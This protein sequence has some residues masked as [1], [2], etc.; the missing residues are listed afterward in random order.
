MSPRPHFH[1]KRKT[2]NLIIIIF[3][4][5]F[6]FY[7]HLSQPC[8]LASSKRTIIAAKSLLTSF[9]TNQW[10]QTDCKSA[11]LPPPPVAENMTTFIRA[12]LTWKTLMM[13]STTSNDC[14]MHVCD[15]LSF[16]SISIN[17]IHRI[18]VCFVPCQFQPDGKQRKSTNWCWNP[19]REENKQKFFYF[20]Q[21]QEISWYDTRLH[22]K[23]TSR[24]QFGPVL[25][26][27]IL[28]SQS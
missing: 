11:I 26:L 17:P 8:Q 28:L 21:S 9:Q 25:S 27:I 2:W 22:C 24:K 5:F 16:A 6:F 3:I 12:H 19:K 14:S 1:R 4:I 13:I 20:I 23:N 18:V 15:W 7:K 10:G